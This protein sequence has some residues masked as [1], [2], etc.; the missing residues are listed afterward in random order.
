M[1]GQKTVTPSAEGILASA[2]AAKTRGLPPLEKW[3]P[4]FCGDLDMHIRRDGTWFYQ[5]TPIGRPE[6]VKLFSTILWRE[7][8]RYYLVTPVEKVGITVEDA[9]FV[10][11]DFEAE[12]SGTDQQL[13]F[14]TNLQDEALAGPDH[15]IRV[16]RDAETGE[17]SPYV[18][19]RRNLEAL[20]D[21]KSFYRL[22]D[23]GAHHDGWFGLWSGGEFFGIIPSDEL[24]DGS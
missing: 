11:V 9:P 22:V 16:V 15:P 8:D 5:G 14:V 12:G 23:I 20:I 3:N 13:R 1:S 19:I 2:K 4:P 7:E 10:A 24:P 21:R 6:L 18:L 17:P